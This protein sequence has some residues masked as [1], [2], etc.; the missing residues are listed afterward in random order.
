GS[1]T[2][3]KLVVGGTATTPSNYEG[4]GISGGGK[5]T[6]GKGVA[7]ET[8]LPVFII[9]SDSQLDVHGKLEVIYPIPSD[10]AS[11]YAAIQGNGSTGNGGTTINIYPGAVILSDHGLAMYIPQDGTVN[12]SGGTIT[13]T[14]SAIGIK[15]G[16]L[17]ISGGTIKA[18]GALVDPPTGWS[19]GINGSGCA[20]QIESNA[21]YTGGVKV[22]ITGGTIISTNGYALY[23]YVA[24]ETGATAVEGI[25][26]SGGFFSSKGT[27]ENDILTSV[28]AVNRVNITGG[29]FSRGTGTIVTA[30]VDSTY[31]I[32]IPA[33]VNFGTL[34]KDSGVVT[35]PFDVTAQ[36]VLIDAD[37][38]I[39]VNV[40]SEFKMD[41]GK[42][43]PTLLA[44][45][46][47]DVN[48]GGTKLATGGLF[49]S[50]TESGTQNG[51]SAVDTSTITAAGSY[52]GTM[53]FKIAY[54]G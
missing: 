34:I 35:M 36:G 22:N 47:F 26:I 24:A 30:N 17:N 1:A 23:E 51:R 3:S 7:I 13:G 25:N 9:G 42:T 29:T 5:A 44:Y 19:D 10:P 53:V 8:G 33:A 43:T 50:F 20:I 40:E 16:V 2:E 31:T 4:I 54:T 45:E 48:S 12:V 38:S 27:L 18:T 21:S 15:S 49:A 41:D 37:A 28:E 14:D 39:T 11:A 52:S 46:L 6:V 32:I